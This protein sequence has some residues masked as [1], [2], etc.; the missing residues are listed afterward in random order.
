MTGENIFV[1][2]ETLPTRRPRSTATLL[3]MTYQLVRSLHVAKQGDQLF[4]FTFELEERSDEVPVA[5]RKGCA[6]FFPSPV[7]G[8]PSRR[9]Q[10]HDLVR[11]KPL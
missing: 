11:R 7:P 1:R 2:L 5:K 9:S 3:A 10:H 6:K 4:S 8:H